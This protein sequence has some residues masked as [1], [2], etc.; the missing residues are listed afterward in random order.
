MT[1]DVNERVRAEWK[2]DTTPFERVLTV[3][4]RTYEAQSADE[5]AVRA[6]TTP[7]TARKHLQQ[8]ADSGFVEITSSPD[9]DATLYRRSNESLILERARDIID[10]MDT[11]TVVDRIGEM[12]SDINRYREEYGVESPEDAAIRGAD[13]DH[14]T[15]RDWQTTRRNLGITRAALALIEAEEDY[16][17]AAGV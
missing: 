17:A 9:R 16:R 13:V 3:M 5:I 12:Q 6:L 4:K 2:D 11:D 7:T 10:E 1:E 14:E 8:L 15:L